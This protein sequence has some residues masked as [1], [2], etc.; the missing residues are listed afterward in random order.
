LGVVRWAVVLATALTLHAQDERRVASPNGQTEFRIF[1]AQSPQG[2]LSRLAY[3]V[4]FSGKIAVKTSFL[5]INIV[6][7]EPILG[8]NVGLIASKT[9]DGPGY[10]AL[11]LDYMQNGSIGRRIDLEVRA[12][13]DH[14]EF[15]YIIPRSTALDE[16][17]V[18]DEV[19]EVHGRVQVSEIPV[20]GFPA[21]QFREGVI[22]LSHG[23]EGRTP[24]VCPWRVLR[25]GPEK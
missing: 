12:F 16:I 21:M 8:E 13:D 18:E 7:Q 1:I 25:P 19:T 15:R 3:E 14:V 5:G 24:L 11:L 23:Y 10:R 9:T 22:H 6:N 2:G 4:L 17:L 20:N